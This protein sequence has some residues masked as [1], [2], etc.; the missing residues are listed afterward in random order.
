[1][2][3]PSSRNAQLV[4]S[5]SQVID[6]TLIFTFDVKVNATFINCANTEEFIRHLRKYSIGH[7]HSFQTH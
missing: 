6:R 1:M 5:P 2:L 4:L 3:Q 7:F